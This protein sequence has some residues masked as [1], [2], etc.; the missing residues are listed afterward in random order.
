MKNQVARGLVVSKRVPS[1]RVGS[2][3]G[4]RWFWHAVMVASTL[5]AAATGAL[6]AKAQTSGF[7]PR[8]TEK[9]FDALESGQTSANR[10]PPPMPRLARSETAADSKPLF[11]LRAVTV[12]G[13]H[14]LPR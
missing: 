3:H 14:A 7:D 4:P 10:P 5:A 11:I 2:Q 8:Q 1:S 9:R 6:P 13:A 12:S